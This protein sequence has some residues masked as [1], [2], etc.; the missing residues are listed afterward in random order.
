MKTFRNI[1]QDKVNLPWTLLENSVFSS[2]ILLEY[3]LNFMSKNQHWRRKER[4]G[5]GEKG[6]ACCPAHRFYP[7]GSNGAFWLVN[8]L[9]IYSH[10]RLLTILKFCCEKYY[11]S[12]ICRKL[13]N[14]LVKEQLQTQQ[15]LN[16]TIS[17]KKNLCAL[18]FLHWQSDCLLWIVIEM[19]FHWKLITIGSPN[20]SWCTIRAKPLTH[21]CGCFCKIRVLSCRHFLSLPSLSYLF[22]SFSPEAS[23]H[24]SHSRTGNNCYA[25][26]NKMCYKIKWNQL[27]KEASQRCLWMH[28]YCN[29]YGHT[30]E[31]V[32]V[33]CR[34]MAHIGQIIW[35]ITYK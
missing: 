7:N 12:S 2:W 23:T 3:S 25:G 32:L 17:R 34:H 8:G 14:L 6:D 35:W 29:S 18:F 26:Y 9:S 15:I 22:C 1:V 21:F 30:M 4:E 10:D 13:P 24:C 33:M 19:I 5:R 16:A 28:L 20:N 27:R 31:V 11:F